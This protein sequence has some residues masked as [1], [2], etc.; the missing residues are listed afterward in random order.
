[1]RERQF[2][3]ACSGRVVT[4]MARAGWLS[5]PPTSLGGNQCGFAAGLGAMILILPPLTCR[6]LLCRHYPASRRW[7]RHLSQDAQ[8]ARVS[9]HLAAG[10]IPPGQPARRR[11]YS[12]SSPG[13]DGVICDEADVGGMNGR[14]PFDS[15]P[16]RLAVAPPRRVSRARAPAL[17]WM[18]VSLD[19]GD[20]D[21]S[22]T[23]SVD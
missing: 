15:A 23:P 3:A 4:V 10:E 18:G 1:M 16:G 7:F 6:A 17:H 12:R 5:G 20:R 2:P 9:F 8:V 21:A 19:L 14:V 11:R 13:R 22:D